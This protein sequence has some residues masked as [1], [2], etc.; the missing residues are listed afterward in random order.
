[1]NDLGARQWT[2]ISTKMR[3]RTPKQC[4]ERYHQNLKPS[5]VHNPIT[6]QEAAIIELLVT[7]LGNKWAEIA[8]RLPGRSDN[9]VKNWWNGHQNRKRRQQRKNHQRM[10]DMHTLA[11]RD[12]LE[13]QPPYQMALT[14]PFAQR[15]HLP[16]LDVHHGVA[17]EPRNVPTCTFHSPLPSP[18]ASS[19][20]R[21]ETTEHQP[22]YPA[23]EPLYRLDSSYSRPEPYRLPPLRSLGP[24]T[25]NTY[26]RLPSPG[27]TPS[28]SRPP[29]VPNSPATTPPPFPKSEAAPKKDVR[30]DLSSLLTN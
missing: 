22:P 21:S 15:H 6:E 13:Y 3:N 20:P 25:D 28:R 1:V 23:Y 18:T 29:T 26:D 5:L 12:R 7:K 9:A 16:R 30:M 14:Q 17:A 11:G 27:A 8:R 24:T 4:R 10:H 2:E 19:S